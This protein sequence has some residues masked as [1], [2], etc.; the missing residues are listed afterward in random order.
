MDHL[1]RRRSLADP[2]PPDLPVESYDVSPSRPAGL[3]RG[4]YY[5]VIFTV[6]K[7]SGSYK[8]INRSVNVFSPGKPSYTSQLW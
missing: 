4:S 8:V 1:Y 5:S 6:R 2:Y 3:P 7:E